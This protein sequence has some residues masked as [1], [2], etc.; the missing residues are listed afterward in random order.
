MYIHTDVY[1]GDLCTLYKFLLIFCVCSHPTPE[2]D[3]CTLYKFL[4]IFCVHTQK[5]LLIF[6]LHTQKLRICDLCTLYKFLLIF[7]VWGG[8]AT[9][10]RLLKKMCLYCRISSLL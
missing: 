2:N 1:L 5:L 3:L 8:V 4:F 9:V 10:S 7:C 6:C